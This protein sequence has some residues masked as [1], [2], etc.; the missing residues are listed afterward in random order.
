MFLKH[1][2]G[3][4]GRLDTVHDAPLKE[5]QCAADKEANLHHIEPKQL[6]I[7]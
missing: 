2:G 5:I 7:A 3:L 1:R 6:I 4:I